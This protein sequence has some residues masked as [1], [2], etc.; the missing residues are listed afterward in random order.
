MRDA[1][2]GRDHPRSSAPRGLRNCADMK[3]QL[4]P[5]ERIKFFSLHLDGDLRATLSEL[6]DVAII[7]SVP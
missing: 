2:L 5:S 1:Q 3:N 7:N 4:A 6:A